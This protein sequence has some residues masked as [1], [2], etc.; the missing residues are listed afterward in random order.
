M[1]LQ[2]TNVETLSCESVRLDLDVG[3]RNV[4]QKRRLADIGKTRDDKRAGVGVDRGQ[5]TQMLPDLLEVDKRV[6]E[7][8]ANCRHATQRRLLQL[9]TLEERL[10][11]LE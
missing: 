4:L 2:V 8:L 6:L 3:A 11:V 7:P 10:S 5:T 9:L 1:N